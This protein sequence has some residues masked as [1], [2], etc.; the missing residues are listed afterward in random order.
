MH[1]VKVERQMLTQ[2]LQKTSRSRHSANGPPFELGQYPTLTGYLPGESTA[3]TL[4]DV[5]YDEIL[6]GIIRG[7]LASGTELK[8]TRIA[9]QME[10]SRTPVVQALARLVADGIVT[11]QTN[12]RAV[13]RAGAEN[14]LVDVHEL[15]QQL[16]PSAARA[17]AGGIPG[18]VLDD[19]QKLTADA[20]GCSGECLRTASRYV[21]YALHLAIA[22]FCGNLAIGESIRKCWMYKRVSYDA[23][24]DSPEAIDRGFNEHL[25]ILGHLNRGDGSAA[26][27]AMRSHLDRAAAYRMHQRI[28]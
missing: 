2:D 23:V 15:R 12:Y 13:V 5:V 8:S 10:V 11:Q 7:N 9:Q 28:V 16:E 14:W 17:A 19:L 4:V 20:R 25:E 1:Y 24:A 6:I 18:E 21:D 3:R 27:Q 26:Y 22:E